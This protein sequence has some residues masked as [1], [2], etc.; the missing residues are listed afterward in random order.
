MVAASNKIQTIFADPLIIKEPENVSVRLASI[1]NMDAIE[2]YKLITE[3][4]NRR[5]AKI[6]TGA[7]QQ[8]CNAA[9]EI[10]GIGIESD[11]RRHYPTGRLAAHTVGF[12]SID[13]QGLEGIE[14]QYDKELAGSPGQNVFFADAS[15]IRRPVR[16]KGSSWYSVDGNGIILTI[17][18]AIQQFARTEL[19]KQYESYECRSAVAIVAEPQTGAVLAM[20]S[21]PDFEPNNIRFTEANSIRNRV[22]TD[23]FEPGSLL[24]PIAAAIAVDDGVVGLEEKIFCENG[25]Y[26][27]R[28]FGRIGEYGTHRFEDLTVREILVH[29][30]NIGM[31]KIGQRLGKAGLYRGMKLFG[32]GKKTRIDLPG[33]AAGFL[34]PSD[35]WTGYS[36][37][38]IP[39]GQEISVTAIQ[40]VRAFCMLANGGQFVRPYIVKA[41]VGN[42][43]EVVEQKHPPAGV[44]FVVKPEVAKWIVTEAMVGVVN[45]GTGK[46]ARLEKWQVFGKTGTAQLAKSGGKGYS[47]TDYVASFV[48]GAPADDPAVVVLVSMFKPNIKLG[49]GY[50]G[51]TVAAPVAAGILEKALNYLEKRK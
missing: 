44:G 23:A 43:G 24:K 1:V 10:Y 27:G 28:G 41:V 11:W 14:L 9:D 39:F 33:E 3:S 42:D 30:S 13:N 5:Y 47:E 36:V 45:E 16:L 7:T 49:R 6:K 48:A 51:G 4:Q 19:L 37:T 38:R 17:D 21:L 25:N 12:T 26:R 32:F 50:T 18:A 20:V 34:Q 8:Q 15:S 46:K 22:I 40:L 29:S 2:I 31:A 35:K